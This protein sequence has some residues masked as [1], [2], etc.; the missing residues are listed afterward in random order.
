MKASRE[1]FTERGEPEDPDETLRRETRDNLHWK[2]M[3]QR[4]DKELGDILERLDF[5]LMRDIIA[6]DFTRSTGLPANRMNFVPLA[7]FEHNKTMAIG[8]YIAETNT[9]ALNRDMIEKTYEGFDRQLATLDTT[10]HEEGHAASRRACYGN[11]ETDGRDAMVV[12]QVIA[13][14]RYTM[15]QR[16]TEIQVDIYEAFEEGVNEKCAREW[17]RKYCERKGIPPES[18]SRFEEVYTQRAEGVDFK[19]AYSEEVR[20]VDFMILEIAKA[21]ELDETTVW[22]AIKQGKFTG[23]GLM[24]DAVRQGL[25]EIFGKDFLDR[26]AAGNFRA[27]MED[28]ASAEASK[29]TPAPVRQKLERFISSFVKPVMKVWQGSREAA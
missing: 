22:E 14:Y 27:I 18:I 2:H 16:F 11:T 20:F 7:G 6:E 13:G 19:I 26:L 28:V 12:K 4:K 3:V 15:R 17:L 1:F 5:D 24:D 23:D 8:R 21:T 29:K 10:L 25:F 9:I